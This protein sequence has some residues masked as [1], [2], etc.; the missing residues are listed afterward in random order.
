M[1]VSKEN[2]KGCLNFEEN[3]HQENMIKNDICHKRDMVG[4]PRV[5]GTGN[6][7]VN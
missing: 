2:C 7:I 4:C 1:I 3:P 5:D 6:N